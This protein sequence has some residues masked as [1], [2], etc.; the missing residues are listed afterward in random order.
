[1]CPSDCMSCSGDGS[2]V[3]SALT[4]KCSVFLDLPPTKKSRCKSPMIEGEN[5][6]RGYYVRGA[7]RAPTSPLQPHDYIYFFQTYL[8]TKKTWIVL[9]LFLIKTEKV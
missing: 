1:M 4:F 5:L 3:L 8:L 7:K 6:D 2:D 9:V